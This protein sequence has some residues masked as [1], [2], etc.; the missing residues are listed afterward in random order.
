MDTPLKRWICLG[1]GFSYDE[2]LGLPEHGLAAGTRWKDIPEDWVCPDCGTPK[3]SFEM[4]EIGYAAGQPRTRQRSLTPSETSRG[5][6]P[7][8]IR[9]SCA[10][11]ERGHDKIR[12][13]GAE[14]SYVGG[15][16]DGFHTR[17]RASTSTSTRAAGPALVRSACSATRPSTAGCGY[18]MHSH[19]NFVICAFVLEGELTHI[20]TAGRGTVDQLRAGDYYVFSAGSGGKHSELS[21]SPENMNAIY[22]WFLPE[23]TLF[24]AEYHQRHFDLR[25]RRDRIVQ[26]GRRS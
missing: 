13:T 26:L 23:P 3:A 16:P 14:L 24:A 8:P 21:I 15:H 19:H 20:N 6:Q 18:N 25:T 9:S 12:S 10:P 1:C 7:C 5:A 17:L 4:V 22:L 2:A 11:I